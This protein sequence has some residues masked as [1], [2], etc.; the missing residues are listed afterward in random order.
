M[1]TRITLSAA[2][3]AL[4][5]LLTACSTPAPAKTEPPVPD[6]GGAAGGTMLAE[7]DPAQVCEP[8]PNTVDP[9][10]IVATAQFDYQPFDSLSAMVDRA[11]AA[12]TG[13]VS[14]WLPR[15][16]EAWAD[17][18]FSGDYAGGIVLA[19][20]VDQVA[21]GNRI[22]RGD[23]V[24]VWWSDG[25]PLVPLEL[26]AQRVPYGYDPL[27]ADI[28][29]GLTAAIPKGTRVVVAGEDPASS[30]GRTKGRGSRVPVVSPFI[31]GLLFEGAHGRFFGPM[32]G[33]AD[34]SAIAAHAAKMAGEG[35]GRVASA[36]SFEWLRTELAGRQA[37]Q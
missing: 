18:D 36:G 26:S 13:C 29:A 3:L 4:I 21:A 5:A 7:D 33:D 24:Y 17:P 34:L 30:G 28:V 8:T 2:G 15:V 6:P 10:S 14:E 23:T 19:V 31:Q 20:T 11:D 1:R 25:L 32:A 35:D 22:K 16:D 37:A 12:F 27:L 9:A